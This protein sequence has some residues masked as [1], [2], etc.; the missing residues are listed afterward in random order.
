MLTSVLSKQDQKKST[1]KE[2]LHKEYLVVSQN[3]FKHPS[4]E[5]NVS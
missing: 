5:A 4:T 2:R 1:K 3:S